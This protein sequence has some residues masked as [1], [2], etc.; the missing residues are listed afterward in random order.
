MICYKQLDGSRRMNR[1]LT[2]LLALLCVSITTSAQIALKV[3]VS[4][5]RMQ[6]T[7][8]GGPVAFLIRAAVTPTVIL[9]LALYGLSVSLWL[10]VLAKSDVSYAY[11]FVGLGFVFTAVYAAMVLHEPMGFWRV[12]GI[13]LIVLGVGFVSRS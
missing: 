4:G 7:L 11:P 12:S 5:L 10:I 8:A 2:I 9:G 3:G 6:Q 13:V 1:T